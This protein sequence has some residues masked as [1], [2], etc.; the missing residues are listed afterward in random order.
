MSMAHR[1]NY[2]DS[3]MKYTE[4]NLA[5]LSHHKSNY[6]FLF[7]CLRILIVIYVLFCVFCFIVWIQCT[8]CV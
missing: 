7:L 3:G 2:D 8:V 4:K 6:V 1:C 5:T